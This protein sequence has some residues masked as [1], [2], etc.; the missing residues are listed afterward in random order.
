MY[1]IYCKTAGFIGKDVSIKVSIFMRR[2]LQWISAFIYTT[3]CVHW[4]WSIV[5]ICIWKKSKTVFK[6]MVKRWI[7]LEYN[8]YRG[9]INAEE[10]WTCIFTVMCRKMQNPCHFTSFQGKT[11][12][13]MKMALWHLKYPAAK[14]AGMFPLINI[15]HR[16]RSTLQT[17]EIMSLQHSIIW[18]KLYFLQGKCVH[19]D[20][21][22]LASFILP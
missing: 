3:T 12:S 8:G 18:H 6:G 1:I 14:T 10:Q 11:G 16:S 2:Q 22:Y 21:Y 19:I 5:R 20:T 9:P 15:N 7:N 13:I 4:Q 17:W